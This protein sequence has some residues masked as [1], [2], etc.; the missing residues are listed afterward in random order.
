MLNGSRLWNGI[1][2]IVS[3][4]FR[5]LDEQAEKATKKAFEIS[6]LVLQ[7][8]PT[9]PF[10][11]RFSP[12]MHHAVSWVENNPRAINLIINYTMLMATVSQENYLGSIVHFLQF[13]VD[14]ETNSNWNRLLTF[15]NAISIGQMSAEQWQGITENSMAYT[16][17]R[18]I[19]HVSNIC[20]NSRMIKKMAL[21]LDRINFQQIG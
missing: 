12:Q 14:D 21:Q 9:S 3:N 20:Y 18:S 1:N 2:G 4:G 13:F 8:H 5:I 19:T 15:I 7:A 11:N 17:A 10:A 6:Y 16:L